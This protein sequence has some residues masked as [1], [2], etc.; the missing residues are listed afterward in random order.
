MEMWLFQLEFSNLFCF[1]NLGNHNDFFN[2]KRFATNKKLDHICF[3]MCRE[4][5]SSYVMKGNLLIY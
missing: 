2:Q 1:Q 3:A 4:K 5:L